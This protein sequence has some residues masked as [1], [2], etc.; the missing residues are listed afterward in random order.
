MGFA[1]G[2]LVVALLANG[3]LGLA[4]GIFAGGLL[5]GYLAYVSAIPAAAEYGA[6]IRTAFEAYRFDLL[7]QLRVPAPVNLDDERR[8]WSALG[9]FILNGVN[10][11]WPY[12]K[13][14]SGPL[15]RSGDIE[16]S[17]GADGA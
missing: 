9:A 1:I 6:Y 8:L 12:E 14:E 10:P 15:L 11:A 16:S 7:A 17:R 2:N 3:S 4:A 5:F 13:A